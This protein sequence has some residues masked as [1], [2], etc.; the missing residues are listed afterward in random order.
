MWFSL[1]AVISFVLALVFSDYHM[2]RND[3]HI[4]VD[5]RLVPEEAVFIRKFVHIYKILQVH[6]ELYLRS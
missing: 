6:R 5:A 1:E 3:I 2:G 4:T